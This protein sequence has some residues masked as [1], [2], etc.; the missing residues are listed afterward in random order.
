MT[1]SPSK[2]PMSAE[3]WLWKREDAFL[4]G[5]YEQVD[6]DAHNLLR[7]VPELEPFADTVRLS[8]LSRIV[9][10]YASYLSSQRATQQVGKR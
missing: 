5:V 7:A 2:K 1:S 3:Q 6:L 8:R 9:S 10:A 4:T